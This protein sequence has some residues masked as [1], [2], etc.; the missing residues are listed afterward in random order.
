[1]KRPCLSKW[2]SSMY[3]YTSWS[4]SSQSQPQQSLNLCLCK[5][6]ELANPKKIR[7]VALMPLGF[8]VAAS[9]ILFV[10]FS[11]ISPVSIPKQ[12]SQTNFNKWLP[13]K[14]KASTAKSI[15]KK[16]IQMA[17]CKSAG[18]CTICARTFA[19]ALF[20]VSS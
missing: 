13:K 5:L 8:F 16:N 14:L 18:T 19:V 15:K 11:G 10:T 20:W 6:Q 12:L 4:A 9:N 1:M 2:L 17:S 3:M 7:G